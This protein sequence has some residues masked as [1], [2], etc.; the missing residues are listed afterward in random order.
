MIKTRLQQ[1]YA[2][3]TAIHTPLNPLNVPPPPLRASS[4]FRVWNSLTTVCRTDGVHSL[5]RGVTPSLARVGL[6]SGMYRPNP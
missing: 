1:P 6:G 2:S 5:W 3:I 4:Q